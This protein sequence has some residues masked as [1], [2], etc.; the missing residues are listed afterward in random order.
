ML[1]NPN[2]LITLSSGASVSSHPSPSA[3]I[4][5]FRCAMPFA[6]YINPETCPF[7]DILLTL[8][9]DLP[10]THHVDSRSRAYHWLFRAQR[11]RRVRCARAGSKGV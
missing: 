7:R 6:R 9:T 5:P 4:F 8:L 3:L 10:F 2:C 1:R 11:V